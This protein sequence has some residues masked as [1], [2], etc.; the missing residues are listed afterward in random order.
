MFKYLPKFI[1]HFIYRLYGISVIDNSD[2]N[3]LLA[4]ATRKSNAQ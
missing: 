2:L 3:A 4:Q 1:R